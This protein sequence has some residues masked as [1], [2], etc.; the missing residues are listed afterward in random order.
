MGLR[1]PP[2][3]PMFP[4]GILSG[5]LSGIHS[6]GGGRQ[7][8]LKGAGDFAASDRPADPPGALFI[9]CLTKVQSGHE[10]EAPVLKAPPSGRLPLS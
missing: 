8:Q 1:K 5:D 2:N 10:A 9:L 7:S 3:C 6:S 4:P